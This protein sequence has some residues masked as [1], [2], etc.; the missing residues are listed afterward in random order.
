MMGDDAKHL[1]RWRED[2]PVRWD[3]DH[4]LTRR[5][6]AKFLTLGSGLLT[7]ATAALAVA[8][9]S[10]TPAQWP[11][12][13]IPAAASLLPGSAVLFRYPTDTDPCIL[14]RTA[15]GDFRAYSQVCTHLSCAV[16]YEASSNVIECPCHR[17]FFGVEDGRPVAGPPTRALPRVRLERRGDGVYATGMEI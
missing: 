12:L 11:V 7:A 1:E 16:R 13:K 3:A 9:R 5:E 8:G 2:F 15:A 6:L 14:I 10:E 4:Y 17:G